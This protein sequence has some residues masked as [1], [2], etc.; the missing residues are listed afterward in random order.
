MWCDWYPEDF[1]ISK[2]KHGLP[3]KKLRCTDEIWRRSVD[4]MVSKGMNQLVIDVGEG[5]VY[6]SHPELAVKGSWSAEKLAA[7]VQAV[8]DRIYSKKYEGELFLEEYA[9]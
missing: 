4:H 2:V 1:D 7:E 5:L 3:D 9:L 8:L 6:P